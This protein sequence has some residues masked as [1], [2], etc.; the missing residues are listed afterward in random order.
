MRAVVSL[1]WARLRHR[2][3]RWLLVALGVAA[4]TV[5]PVSAQATSTV[6]SG[7]ALRH[8]L[9]EL[10]V[11]DRSLAA[12]R[13]GL[14]ETPPGIATLDSTARDAFAPL[15]AGP[16]LVEMLSRSISDGAGHTFYFGAADGLAGRITVTSG[17]LPTSCTPTR[18]EVVAIGTGD[19]AVSPDLGLVVVG[20][21]VRTDPL[22]FGG[23]FDP[24]D[25]APMLLADGVTAA[26]QLDSL[27][28]FQRNYIWVTAVDLDRVD[29]LGV[30]GYLAR[31]AR[32]SVELYGARL[33]LSAPD[34]VLRAEY[35][36]AQRSSRRF[37]LLGASAM[38][39]LLGFAAIGAIGLRRDH[40]STVELLR[41]RGATRRQVGLLTAIGALVPVAVGVVL[42]TAAGYGLARAEGG[43]FATVRAAAPTIAIGAFAAALVVAV[44]LQVGAGS[45][46]SAGEDGPG[47]SR[48]AWRAVDITVVAGTV[49]AALAVARGAVTTQSLAGGTDPLLLAL[50]VI[51]VVC[52]GLV[53]GRAWPALTA[54]LA[55]L[56]PR[57]ALA[58]RLGLVGAVRS[59]LRPVATAAFLAAA[60]GIVAFAGS[61]QATLAQ[62]AR[63]QSTFAVPLDVT[64]RAGQTLRTPLQVAPVSAYERAGATAFPVVR[65]TATVRLN[66]SQS[67]VP[68]LIGV[69]PAAL[70]SIPNWSDVVGASSADR[71]RSGLSGPAGP[72]GPFDPSSGPTDVTGPM[73]GIALPAGAR[74]LAFGATGPVGDLD[75][76]AFIRQPDGR[77]VAT[78][79]TLAGARLVADLDAP[80][81]AGSVLFAIT[82]TENNF[83]NTRR[84]HRVGEGGNDAEA[85]VGHVELSGVDF[86][87]WTGDAGATGKV[88]AG[89]DRIAVDYELTGN[90]IVLRP[91]TPAPVP[92]PV[93]TDPGTAA[94]ASGGLLT[95]GL[96]GSADVTARIVGVLPRFPTV[97]SS[98]VVAS[99][100]GL[101]D[102]LDA[103]APG[104]GSVD[105][106]WLRSADPQGLR[107]ALGAA[108]FDQVAVDARQARVDRLAGDPVARGATGL[109]TGSAVLA[110][111]VAL[112]ALV[113]LVVAERRDEAAQLYAWESDG[114]TP[115]TLR[116]SLLLRAVAVVVVAVPGGV[117]IG[118]LLSRLSTALVRLTAVGTDPVPPLALAVS[119]Q[120]SVLA[121]A[122]GIAAG[123][124]VCAAVAAAALREPLPPR[125]EEG[126]R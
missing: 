43:G 30:D 17:R 42:G 3:A 105:E 66:A 88:S 124:V 106:L 109:L 126:L 108:P 110:F 94:A 62:G 12:V 111:V 64:V 112:L 100:R 120:W 65:G 61:Y 75:L 74:S 101:A 68:Q 82:L 76:S 55:R 78:P 1:A 21:A 49:V 47:R 26:A 98:F 115:R 69:D 113:L 103:D 18:C 20:R 19:P 102:A 40:S 67:V 39:L 35:D 95:L 77:D 25:G 83:A 6:V 4:A 34:Q 48:A 57:R 96:G 28:A 71:V 29:V 37:A 36:R 31:S 33:S 86:T 44:F 118:L 89:P 9:A 11:G 59:P 72:S 99:A 93:F 97:G 13:S 122:A 90:R 121:V 91:A 52:G 73:P 53:V 79:L 107:A 80:L 60:T 117:L 23:S 119:A 125:P 46:G 14:R 10:P 2:P 104:T 22:L 32:A 15:A 56:L 7:Q 92:L 70:A 87:G 116:R 16:V 8:G 27:S 5:L 58:P 24:G 38:A 63:D 85:L 41:R 81:P 50:P 51:T 54:G 114:V 84:Q 45:N 123:L